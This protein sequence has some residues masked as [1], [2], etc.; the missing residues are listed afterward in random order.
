MKTPGHQAKIAGREA[1]QRVIDEL[2]EAGWHTTI[3]PELDYAHKTDVITTCP[4]GTEFP[5]QISTSPKSARQQKTLERRGVTPIATGELD[6]H[7]DRVS[8]YICSRIC[9]IEEC[10]LRPAPTTMPVSLTKL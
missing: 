1:E 2:Q 3:S 9:K 4:G 7:G 5:I 8:N 10:T 6:R